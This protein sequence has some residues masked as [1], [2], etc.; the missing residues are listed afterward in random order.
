MDK[1]E[2]PVAKTE[3]EWKRELSP[4]QYRVLRQHGTERAGTSP[5]NAEKRNGQ[6]LCAGCGAELAKVPRAASF[7]VTWCSPGSADIRP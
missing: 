7:P 6:F 3:D 2:R 5:L 1:N 4:E